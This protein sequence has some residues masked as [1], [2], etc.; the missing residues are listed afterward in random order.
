MGY[1]EK[2]LKL[3]SNSDCYLTAFE[4]FERIPFVAL[5]TVMDRCCK[6]KRKGLIK[7]RYREGKTYEY[8][9]TEKGREFLSQEKIIVEV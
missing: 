3:L 1:K 9:I 7:A 2:I 6:M 8:Q 4:I 5:N